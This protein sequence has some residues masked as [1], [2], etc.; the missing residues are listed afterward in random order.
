[1]LPRL[2]RGLFRHGPMRPQYADLMGASGL[3]VSDLLKAA[4]MI[5]A[6]VASLSF[7]ELRRGSLNG[8]P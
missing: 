3:L 6:L 8:P 1:M 4:K 2:G 5:F 7:F